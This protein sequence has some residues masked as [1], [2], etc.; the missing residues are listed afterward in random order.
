MGAQREEADHGQIAV[1]TRRHIA[2]ARLL[3][4]PRP[5]LDTAQMYSYVNAKI[6]T[7]SITKN[8]A[9]VN[10]KIYIGTYTE[11]KLVKRGSIWLPLTGKSGICQK[12]DGHRYEDL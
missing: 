7:G 9:L 8:P 3:R 12:L 6:Y 2:I 5:L 1:T 11:P 10:T 4:L